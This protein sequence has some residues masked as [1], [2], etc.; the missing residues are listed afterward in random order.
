LFSY[1]S[2]YL[3][4][5]LFSSSFPYKSMYHVFHVASENHIWQSQEKVTMI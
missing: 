5:F 4:S 3:L 2:F 1:L